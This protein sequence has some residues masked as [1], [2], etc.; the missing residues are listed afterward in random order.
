MWAQVGFGVTPNNAG[1]NAYTDPMLK[2]QAQTLANAQG[3]V[4]D[5]GE[6]I[7]GGFDAAE[8]QAVVDY[9]NGAGLDSVLNQVAAAQKQALGK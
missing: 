3:F 2:K 4:P 5:L 1:T 8:R 7:P 9:L 6:A